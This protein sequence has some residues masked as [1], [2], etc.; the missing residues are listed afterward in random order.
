MECLS[1]SSIPTPNIENDRQL[2]YYGRE[3]VAL[4]EDGP[5]PAERKNIREKSQL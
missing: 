1:A 3:V 2:L 5:T 4:D